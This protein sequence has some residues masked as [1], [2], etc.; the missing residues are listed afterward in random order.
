MTIYDVKQELKRL[1]APKNTS[2]ELVDVPAQQFLAIDGYGDPNTAAEYAAAV[3]A[4]YA[5]A[6]TLKFATKTG[7]GRDF[8]VAPLEALWW[9]AELGAFTDRA[10][11]TWQWTLLISQPAWITAPMIRA[12][13]AVAFEKKKLPEI[14]TVRQLEMKEGRCA[15]ALHIGSYDEEGPLLAELHGPFFA[16]NALD[17]AGMHHEIYLSD[18]RRTEAAKLRTVLRQPVQTAGTQ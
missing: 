13:K 11:D 1:Y 12:A 6:Y 2:W 14:S 7:D 17:F 8:V 4:L 15:Q 9:S 16:A 3:Q 5:V 10:K 18:P